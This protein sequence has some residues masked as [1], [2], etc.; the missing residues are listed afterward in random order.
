MTRKC[1]WLGFVG[2]FLAWPMAAPVLGQEAKNQPPPP[3]PADAKE[4]HAEDYFPN[5]Q[6]EIQSTPGCLGVEAA[7]STTGKEVIFAWFKDKESI[8]KWYYSEI[9]QKLMNKT[10]PGKMFRTPLEN[11]PDDSG[12]ILVITSLTYD[13]QAKLGGR[14]PFSQLA[15]ELYTPLKGGLFV[16][17]R[18]A[19]SALEVPEMLEYTNTGPKK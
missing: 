14:F 7:K 12:P 15:I 16:N 1:L 18:F 4:F 8:L 9:H 13:P 6:M 11:V 3:L 17:G 10:F 19:P 5:L 2:A